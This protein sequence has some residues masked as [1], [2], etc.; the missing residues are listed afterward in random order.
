MNKILTPF[1]IL[2]EKKDE[3]NYV[4]SNFSILIENIIQ[5][6]NNLYQ[7]E[8]ENLLN[9]LAKNHPW[10]EILSSLKIW[11]NYFQTIFTWIK[12][13]NDKYSQDFADILLDKAK[14]TI[15]QVFKNILKIDNKIIWND[16]KNFVL[17]FQDLN[18]HQINTLEN[19]S[20]YLNEYLYQSYQEEIKKRNLKKIYNKNNFPL[21]LTFKVSKI[22]SYKN[23]WK[24][25]YESIIISLAKTRSKLEKEAVSKQNWY[26]NFMNGW[27]KKEF[28]ENLESENIILNNSKTVEIHK[29][30]IEDNTYTIK[31]IN[32]TKIFQIFDQNNTE[33]QV[34]SS[35]I[36][37]YYINWKI[38]K[39]LK[40]HD[41]ITKTYYTHNKNDILEEE[42]IENNIK[43]KVD[44]KSITITDIATWIE[45]KFSLYNKK[46]WFYS[47]LLL[48]KVRKKQLPENLA[49][50]KKIKKLIN[51]INIDWEF[52]FPEWE[53]FHTKDYQNKINEYLKIK[54]FIY[55]ATNLDEIQRYLQQYYK[56]WLNIETFK[57]EVSKNIWTLIF[58]D[59][60][61]LWIYNIYSH[62]IEL[63][64]VLNW[65]QTLND[66]K[67]NSWK[68]VTKIIKDL[69]NID[70]IK[71]HPHTK[72]WDE[73]IIFHKNKLWDIHNTIINIQRKAQE[74]W[75]FCRITTAKKIYIHKEHNILE[76]LELQTKN[77]KIL[78]KYFEKLEQRRIEISRY[79]YE[80]HKILSK[81]IFDI[82]FESE[83]KSCNQN[84]LKDKLKENL[85]IL[86]TIRKMKE[87][88]L[89][90]EEWKWIIVIWKNRFKINETIDENNNFIKGSEFIKFLDENLVWRKK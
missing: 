18:K 26:I 51:I 86:D 15:T 70:E 66:A 55:R 87:L 45:E 59:I 39:S 60:K 76:D 12:E 11:D 79:I 43:Y 61:N 41:N 32:E 36:Y 88:Y 48:E 68:L 31:K 47:I 9:Q 29:I 58:F 65:E 17:K 49:I 81:N 28:L 4:S 83:E 72:W 71:N 37:E 80:K 27:Y 53:N 40:L 78:E 19:I 38:P 52:I 63:Q 13:I 20:T 82:F 69:T 7:K 2:N 73:W 62:H 90:F 54:S 1:K 67:L 46:Y 21:Q 8:K 74:L 34:L 10:L 56:W 57:K 14:E 3:N 77:S 75:I 64:K 50:Y 35:E 16:Y 30:N 42:I 89:S 24:N 44:K 33:E 85:K 84:Y 5:L 6:D 23:Q 22:E 25:V